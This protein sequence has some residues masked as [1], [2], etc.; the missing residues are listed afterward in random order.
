[1]KR[2]GSAVLRSAA[3]KSGRHIQITWTPLGCRC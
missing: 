2:R 3:E 1:L